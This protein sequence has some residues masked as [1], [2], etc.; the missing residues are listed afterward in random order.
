LS[1]PAQVAQALPPATRLRPRILLLAGILVAEALVASMFLDGDQLNQQ[2][3]WLTYLLSRWAAWALRFS[4]LFAVLFGASFIVKPGNQESS[5]P[6]VGPLP[7]SRAWLA[8]VA[9]LSCFAGISYALYGAAAIVPYPNFMA[10]L[11]GAC[12]AAVAVSAALAV[13]PVHTWIA[14]LVRTRTRLAGSAAA[15]ALACVLGAMSGQLWE[16][17]R[18]ATFRLVELV[19]HPIVPSLIVQ[20]ERFRIATGVFGVIIAPECSGLE[21]I[22]LLL[23][24][25][26]MWSLAYWREIG[27]ARCLLLLGGGLA[28]LYFLNVLRIATLIL[29]GHHG[30]ANVA[31]AGFHSQAGWIAFSSV[32]VGLTFVARHLA[33]RPLRRATGAEVAMHNPAAP[34]LVPFL[35]AVAAAM[36]AGAASAGFEWLYGLRVL[37]AAMAIWHYRQDLRSLRWTSPGAHAFVTGIMAFGVWMA[38]EAAIVGPIRFHQA[39]APD[40]AAAPALNRVAWLTVRVIGGIVAVPLIEELA[41]RAYLLRRLQ[42]SDFEQV[43]LRRF[44][45]WAVLGSSVVFGALHG[46]RWLAATLSGGLY[47]WAATRRGAISDAVFAHALTNAFIAVLVLFAGTWNLW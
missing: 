23:I 16:P 44:H 12:A 40:L 41:F 17:A 28:T 6:A 11:C 5:P 4:L 38:L 25:G 9:F 37:A 8:H 27:I 14:L 18:W 42:A 45:P 29:I 33:E 35:A 15:A 2:R 7:G 46:E 39:V 30:A 34:L 36:I 47:A 43:P 26:V 32:A 3:G 22:G 13:V 21:G 19:L 1:S 10:A 20:P 24:F 31:K